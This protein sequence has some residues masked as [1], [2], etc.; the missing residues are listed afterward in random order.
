M[1]TIK[2]YNDTGCIVFEKKIENWYTKSNF[3]VGEETLIIFENGI[4]LFVINLS[5]FG[6]MEV[7]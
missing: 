4:T 6:W 3:S 5:C 7:I 1:K 2:I